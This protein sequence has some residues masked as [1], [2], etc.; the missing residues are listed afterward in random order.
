MRAVA[1]TLVAAAGASALLAVAPRAARADDPRRAAHADGGSDKADKPDKPDKS[2]KRDKHA[3]IAASEEGQALRDDRRLTE[4][5]DR[6]RFCARDACPALLRKDCA[7]WLRDV[8]TRLPT[9]VLVAED[10][11]HRDLAQVKVSIDGRPLADALD[12]RAV[13]VDPGPHAFRFVI[14]GEAPVD[15]GVVVREGDKNRAITA[16]FPGHGRAPAAP[17]AR[18]IEPE[19]ARPKGGVPASAFVL[20]GVGLA[21]IGSFAYFGWTGQR[22]A[23]SLRDTCGRTRACTQDQ[24]DSVRTKLLVADVSLGVGVA[25]IGLATYLA[26]AGASDAPP[27]NA[28]P[29]EARDAGPGRRARRPLVRVDRSIHVAVAPSS[30]GVIAGLDATF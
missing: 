27:P 14:D 12:G 25:A 30:S 20:G 6:L 26:I 17:P 7:D 1:R 9:V 23:S 8:E 19:K 2:D 18:P 29:R 21:A 22:D 28:G 13:S 11:S 5:R 15:V 3:C 10:A 4:A 16:A 24:V